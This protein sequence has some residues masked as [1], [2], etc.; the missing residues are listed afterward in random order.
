[1]MKTQMANEL[2]STDSLNDL[3]ARLRQ[4]TAERHWEQFHTPKNLASALIVEAAELLEPFQWLSSGRADELGA[5]KL[6]A[7]R[8]EM[9]DVMAYLIM[10]AEQLNIDLIAATNEKIQLNALKYPSDIV[11]GDARKYDEYK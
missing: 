6:Q 8:H 1:M 9:A 10:L 7:V 5:E 4:F 2:V 11:R 3:R